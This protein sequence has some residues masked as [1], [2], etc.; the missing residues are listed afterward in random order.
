MYLLRQTNSS[1]VL[2]AHVLIFWQIDTGIHFNILGFSLLKSKS[3]PNFAH[4]DRIF[5]FFGTKT[6]MNGNVAD[7]A[8]LTS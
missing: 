5:Y 1:E 8:I 6:N 3:M 4:F 7:I 2:G